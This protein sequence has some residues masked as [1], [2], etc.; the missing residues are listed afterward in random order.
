MDLST[1]LSKLGEIKLALNKFLHTNER[2]CNNIVDNLFDTRSQPR[3]LTKNQAE[4]IAKKRNI[5]KRYIWKKDI[6]RKLKQYI[7]WC[8]D[9]STKLQKIQSFQKF[10]DEPLN[11]QQ[12]IGSLIEDTNKLFLKL[13]YQQNIVNRVL[14]K[15]LN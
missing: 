6:K 1:I 15:S 9:T 14:N 2:K 3:P 5:I 13:Q 11:T 10:F 8:K 12:Q 7:N 4:G